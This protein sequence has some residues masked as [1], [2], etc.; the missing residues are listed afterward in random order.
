MKS[1]PCVFIGSI[2]SF[3]SLIVNEPAIANIK[4]NGAY[5][6]RNITIPV[7]QFQKGVLAEVPKKSEPLLA[8]AEVYSYSVSV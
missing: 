1:G 5:R 8:A 6:P 2:I 4:A 7:D 3:L